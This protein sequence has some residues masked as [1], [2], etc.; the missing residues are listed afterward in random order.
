VNLHF[1]R[2]WLYFE[3]QLK[4]LIERSFA[5]LFLGLHIPRRQVPSLNDAALYL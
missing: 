3:V 5:L 1:E 4:I 2:A